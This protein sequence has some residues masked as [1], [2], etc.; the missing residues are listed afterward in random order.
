MTGP[1]L[2]RAYEQTSYLAHLAEGESLCIR[3]GEPVNGLR[4]ESWLFITAWN[5]FSR[6]TTA[7]ENAL[8]DASLKRRLE[9][10]GYEHFPGEGV[11]DEGD[12]QPEKSYL[13]LEVPRERALQL[14]DE[15]E[16]RAVLFGLRDGIAE[17]LW[18]P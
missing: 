1:P 7:E 5:P 13:V 12:W 16:Q 18:A 9:Q 6:Q 8:R 4:C 11:P 2:R 14:R 17:L 3:I 10:L 15:F